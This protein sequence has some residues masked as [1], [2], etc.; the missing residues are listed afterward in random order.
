MAMAATNREALGPARRVHLHVRK[1]QNGFWIIAMV[2]WT[3]IVYVLGSQP[4]LYPHYESILKRVATRVTGR[5]FYTPPGTPAAPPEASPQA[6]PEPLRPAQPKVST[7]P[8]ATGTT[9]LK[10]AA[11]A[12]FLN[13]G[14][15]EALGHFTIYG[16][17]G[18]LLFLAFRDM[19][20]ANA[21]GVSLLFA[22]TLGVVD[23]THQLSVPGR[24]CSFFDLAT[25]V[26][27]FNVGFWVCFAILSNWNRIGHL[28]KR[29]KR[30]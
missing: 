1:D 4:P 13:E 17:Q 27:G 10:S 16:T 18:V 22:T 6:T 30:V 12:V 25:D 7:P 14:L 29:S 8:A 5:Q 23:E 21:Y 20:L 15:V 26:T 19:P 9:S 2:V 3:I 11:R 24:T 28:L